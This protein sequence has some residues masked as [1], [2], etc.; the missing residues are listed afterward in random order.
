MDKLVDEQG[1]IIYENIITKYPWIVADNQ[2]CILSPDCDGL[3]CGLLMSDIFN[4]KI[5]GF[6]DGK[7]MALKKE[8]NIKDCIF[9]D[10]EIFRDYVKS[11][12]Q[13]MLLWNKKNI[14]SNWNNFC[15]CISPNNIRK[16]DGKNNFSSKYPLGTIHLLLGIVAHKRKIEISKDGIC[17]LLYVDGTFKNLFNYPEN[18]LSW[19]DFLCAEDE[20]SPL[21]KVFFNDHYTTSSLMIALKDFFAKL[22]TIEKGTD[23]LKADK[24][25]IS[26][27][28]GNP[29]NLIKNN[30]S[31]SIIDAQ[32]NVTNNFIS[33]LSELTEWK[34]KKEK[35]SFDNLSVYKFTKGTIKPNGRN[36]DE[37]ISKNPLSWAMT[38]T[39]AIEYTLEKPDKLLN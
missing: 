26:D 8:E 37:L 18:C 23:K 7:I 9:L 14:P 5:V 12:G 28:D 13:H 4:W 39:L 30:N 19:L 16:Y 15:N 1:K 36:F 2:K 21:Q 34:F 33:V 22:K 24:I 6:Y 35:W 38:S 3:L 31:F 11:L 29:K 10:M 27:K 32:K 25:I 17:P 20:D